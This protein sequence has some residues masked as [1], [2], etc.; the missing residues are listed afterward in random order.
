MLFTAEQVGF[1]GRLARSDQAEINELTNFLF[2][3]DT[4]RPITD[5]IQAK[6][7]PLPKFTFF[8]YVPM[9]G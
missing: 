8:D 4:N 7:L 3:V 5:T 6:K 9:I 1:D 2:R